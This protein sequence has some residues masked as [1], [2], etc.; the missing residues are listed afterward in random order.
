MVPHPPCEL[1]PMSPMPGCRSVHRR[2]SPVTRSA[3]L[4]AIRHVSSRAC[5]ANCHWSRAYFPT[6]VKTDAYCTIDWSD[7]SPRPMAVAGGQGG[8]R[9]LGEC[10]RP[11]LFMTLSTEGESCYL[12]SLFGDALRYGAIM[13]STCRS[14]M[15]L[16]GPFSYDE[17][18]L[19][20]P[21]TRHFLGG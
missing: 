14:E 1:A 11:C 2:P 13:Y 7:R 3:V 8:G 4:Y 6:R 16:G 9:G 5:N 17:V 20:P 10:Y 21:S 12:G 15:L 19:G 18:G